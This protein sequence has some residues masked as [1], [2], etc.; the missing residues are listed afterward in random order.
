MRVGGCARLASTCICAVVAHLESGF[1]LNLKRSA[2][3][4]R[5]SHLYCVINRTRTGPLPDTL[6]LYCT[7]DWLV[8]HDRNALLIESDPRQLNSRRNRDE[9]VWGL[10]LS[11][12]ET[13]EFTCIFT[14]ET[15]CEAAE[16]DERWLSAVSMNDWEEA[17]T[18]LTLGA[19]QFCMSC[20]GCVVQMCFFL[21][22]SIIPSSLSFLSHALENELRNPSLLLLFCR[23]LRTFHDGWEI[24]QRDTFTKSTI[25]VMY[26][27]V[28]LFVCLP[29][30]CNDNTDMHSV[31]F[32]YGTF[33]SSTTGFNFFTHI[34][35]YKSFHPS[36]VT[37]VNLWTV[38]LRR[39]QAW[40][41]VKQRLIITLMYWWSWGRHGDWART[42][43]CCGQTCM[44]HSAMWWNFWR[45]G[46][47]LMFRLHVVL[48]V[49]SFHF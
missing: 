33:C 9:S 36:G 35:H 7:H 3:P 39:L 16:E 23:H 40:S 44:Y 5:S 10:A 17:D 15:V 1:V 42:A 11:S 46:F 34:S 18:A 29:L 24:L 45:T 43:L 6:Q 26:F 27:F 13:T 8:R 22:Y 20:D 31:I 41:D 19:H 14:E 25:K 12:T 37:S 30:T 48:L 21:L 2:S 47:V 4:A 49:L 28:C 38:M 32:C